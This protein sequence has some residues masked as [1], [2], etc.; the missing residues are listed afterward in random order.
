MKYVI[1]VIM[2]VLLVGCSKECPSCQ[3]SCPECPIVQ[4]AKCVCEEKVCE[5]TTVTVINEFN[6]TY[7]TRLIRELKYCES[8]LTHNESYVECLDDYR[9][10]NET[11]TAVRE[12]LT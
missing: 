12:S 5:N 2:A 9:E 8:Q 7:T 6:S 4:C 10:C 3:C 1:L 11:L